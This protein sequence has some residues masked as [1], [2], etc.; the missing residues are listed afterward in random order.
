VRL[1]AAPDKAGMGYFA[2]L[3]G[4]V[5]PGSTIRWH[6]LRHYFAVR[7]LLRGVPIAVVSSWLGHTDINLTVKQYGRWAAEAREQWQWARKMSDPIDALPQRP[8]LG[9]LDGGDTAVV[10]R[11]HRSSSEAPPRAAAWRK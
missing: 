2:E 9:V 6:D 10:E 7:A 3:V 4:A 5:L 8:A 11:E 1:E